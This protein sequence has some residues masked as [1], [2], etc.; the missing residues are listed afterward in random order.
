MKILK[1]LALV[2][3]LTLSFAS[4]QKEEADTVATDSEIGNAK[5]GDSDMNLRFLWIIVNCD[6]VLWGGPCDIIPIGC[7]WPPD[8]CLPTVVIRGEAARNDLNKLLDNIASGDYNEFFRTDEFVRT[9]GNVKDF[10]ELHKL[11]IEN[12]VDFVVESDSLDQRL[13]LMGFDKLVAPSERTERDIMV[14]FE[15]DEN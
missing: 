6:E 9:F 1:L 11:L 4:C 7:T 10:P 3:A 12:K 14:A 2:F 15:I 13:Y 5:V 8:N